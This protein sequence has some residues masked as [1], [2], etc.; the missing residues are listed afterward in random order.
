MKFQ[1]AIASAI[2]LAVARAWAAPTDTLTIDTPSRL[3]LF[4]C[5]LINITWHG[6]QGPYT[7]SVLLA[8]SASETPYDVYSNL[9]A[10]PY[11]WNTNVQDGNNATLSVKDNTGALAYTSSI[12]VNGQ[13]NMSC[14]K[15]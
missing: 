11:T 3:A 13:D 6:G 7:L 8:G 4:Q 12:F 15:N 9:R 1:H 2:S 5:G 14:L 10:S